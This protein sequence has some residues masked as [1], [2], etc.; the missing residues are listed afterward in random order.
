M[1]T[2]EEQRIKAPQDLCSHDWRFLRDRLRKETGVNAREYI[3]YCT[4]CLGA[5]AR[6]AKEFEDD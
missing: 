4:R 3:F 6:P 2:I 5:I 1:I